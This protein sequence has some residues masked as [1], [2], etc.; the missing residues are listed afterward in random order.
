MFP[1]FTSAGAAF[2]SVTK[3]I[4]PT[5]RTPGS[6]STSDIEYEGM[7][8]SLP[9][10]SNNPDAN[11]LINEMMKAKADINIERADIITAK[12][13][14]DIDSKTARKQLREINKRSIMS[15]KLRSMLDNLGDEEDTDS[16]SDE[17]LLKRA[18]GG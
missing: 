3:R 4:A 18:G 8:N 2:N 14:G 12:A 10:L 6:G 5:L 7:L 1:G 13:N 11:A 16:L 15:P 9:R 17:E